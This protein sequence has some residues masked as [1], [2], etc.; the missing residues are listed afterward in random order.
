MPAQHRIGIIGA[1]FAGMAAALRLLREG[2]KDFVIFERADDVGGT[3]RDNTYPGCACDVKTALY[4]FA[5][6]P[7]PNWSE[8]YAGQEE[9]WQYMRK[10]ADE[11][12]LRRYTMFNTDITEARFNASEGYWE[13]LDSNGKSTTVRSL[14]AGLGPL[15]RPKA[16][17]F[18]GHFSGKVLHSAQ[19]DKSYDLKGKKVAVVGTGASAV[20]TVPAIAPIV[21]QLYVYQRTAAWLVHRG[22]R[23][24]SPFMKKVYNRFP[25]ILR[26]RREGQFWS[27][28]FLGL[29]FRGNSS[30][31]RIG[32]KVS[33]MKLKAEVRDPETRKKL[34]PDYTIGCKR[35]LRSDDYWPAFNR[36]N[37]HLVTDGIASL[38]EGGIETV[39]GNKYD[40]DVIIYCTGFNVT[41]F[42]YPI[43]IINA[44]GSE[45]FHTLRE[46]GGAA[47]KGTVVAGFPNF[48]MLMGPNTGLGHNSVVHIMESQLNYVL[49]FLHAIQGRGEKAY[50]SVRNDVQQ[51]YFNRIQEQL[52]G[53]VWASGCNSWYIDENGHNST[54]WPRL[55]TD[56]R[57]ELK[58]FSA[59]DLELSNLA[60]S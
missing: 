5:D 56:F 32:Q 26:L 18:P 57:K 34:T 40:V 31:N 28:E 37:V 4:S 30:I 53:T 29:S 20:Q 2:E 16:P 13:V 49:P 17:S 45:L 12:G 25:F 23:T 1:G 54:L 19:W 33:L 35:I 52:K 36:K 8:T 43:R 60:S 11:H 58:K 22:N 38:Y 48:F 44:N 47:Y 7:N 41:D 46:T 51:E 21:D 50:A 42:N 55:N 39:K 14:I 24:V 6:V 15:N 9:I 10:V 59:E 3:W 27:N